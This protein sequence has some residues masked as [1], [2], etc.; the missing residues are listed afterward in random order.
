MLTNI[1]LFQ[2][3]EMSNLKK[4]FYF[5]IIFEQQPDLFAGVQVIQLAHLPHP[6]F[7]LPPSCSFLFESVVLISITITHG[8]KGRQERGY[9]LLPASK[10]LSR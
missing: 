6:G 1:D 10:Q 8:G 3:P 4:I 9:F 7:S 2:V 5:L